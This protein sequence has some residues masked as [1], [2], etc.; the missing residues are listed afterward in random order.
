MMNSRAS[1]RRGA[2]P[3][4]QPRLAS[5]RAAGVKSGLLRRIGRV[6]LYGAIGFIIGS[7]VL[8]ALYRASMRVCHRSALS[9]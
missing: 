6:A 5:G 8:V 9:R 4:T 2:R 3:R 7:I 1:S